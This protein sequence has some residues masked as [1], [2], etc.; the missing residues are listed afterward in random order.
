MARTYDY[1]FATGTIRPGSPHDPGTRRAIVT[2]LE[3][4][5]ILLDSVLIIPGTNI[6]F[7]RD[8]RLGARH[9]RHDHHCAV[10]L[11]RL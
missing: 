8:H 3:R 4:L 5:S 1:D 7:G 9:R 10:G 2:R 11:Y 6:R